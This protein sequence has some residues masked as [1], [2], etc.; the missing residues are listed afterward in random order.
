M[1][2]VR[3]MVHVENKVLTVYLPDSFTA[4]DVEVIILPASPSVAET[5]PGRAVRRQP[6]P[7]LRGTRISWDLT[8]PVVPESDWDVLK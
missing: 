3:Q 8:E 4:K 7:K 5:T 6:S 1:E 2:A